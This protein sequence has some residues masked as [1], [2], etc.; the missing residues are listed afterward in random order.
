MVLDEFLW[1]KW[2]LIECNSNAPETQKLVFKSKKMIVRTIQVKLWYRWVDCKVETCKRRKCKMNEQKCDE[3]ESE[4]KDDN[5]AECDKWRRSGRKKLKRTGEQHWNGK[6]AKDAK[7]WQNPRKK[8]KK[9]KWRRKK[10]WLR[11]KANR[12][13][14]RES[15]GDEGGRIQTNHTESDDPATFFKFRRTTKLQSTQSLTY[16]E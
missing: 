6:G 7:V 10:S 8:W 2:T 16:K 13:G 4:E 9:R 12:R 15:C 14:A 1:R 3:E 5:H 11:L